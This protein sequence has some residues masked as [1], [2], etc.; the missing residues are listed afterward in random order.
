MNKG[1]LLGLVLTAFATVLYTA[2]VIPASAADPAAK[3]A[4][5]RVVLQVT[6]DGAEH[7]EAVVGNVE[8]LRKAFGPGNSEVEVV[9][10]GKGLGMLMATNKTLAERM[11]K[12]A[13][14]GVVF[15]ACENTMTKKN[16]TKDQL[17]PF[18]T[19]V[20]SGVAE[21]V[22]RQEQGWAYIKS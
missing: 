20:D 22:R 12:L 16:V 4:K 2:S 11:K 3:S 10:H 6:A 13:D 21:V 8:N 17:L 14:D 7:W 15:A 18:V 5:H 19:T 1:T 9:G